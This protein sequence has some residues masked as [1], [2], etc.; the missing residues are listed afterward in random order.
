MR[1]V[2]CGIVFALFFVFVG[3]VK[4][5][6][7]LDG[8]ALLCN[9]GTKKFQTGK[10]KYHPIYGLTFDGGTVTRHQV[11]GY[12][13]T[14]P[15]A[16][17]YYL[18]GTK[19]VTWEEPYTPGDVFRALNRET[20]KYGIDQCFVSSRTKMMQKLNDYIAAAKKKNQF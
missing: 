20:L 14:K 2:I 18:H 15:Y 5:A 17:K 3:N 6:N 19:T 7:D 9:E 8:K 16:R 12:S 1:S 13:I 4:A 10:K 11:D